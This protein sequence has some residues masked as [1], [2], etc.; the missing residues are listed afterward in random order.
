MGVTY[1]VHG[2]DQKGIENCCQKTSS[3]DISLK[4]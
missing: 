2:R 4:T 3:E 1:T